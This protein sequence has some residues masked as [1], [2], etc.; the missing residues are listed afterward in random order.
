VRNLRDNL[1]VALV[2]G[3][4]MEDWQHLVY[5]LI[6]CTAALVLPD[7]VEQQ[8]A[9]ML[10]RARYL[11]YQVMPIAVQPVIAIRPQA[12][13]AWGKLVAHYDGHGT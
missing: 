7:T 8:H 6:R 3:R 10:L 2:I 9:I 11:Q 1:Q 4:Y 13:A 12:V 5:V